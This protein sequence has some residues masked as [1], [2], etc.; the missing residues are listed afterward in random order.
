M[1]DRQTIR[2]E[3]LNLHINDENW[4]VIDCR[5]D[6]SDSSAGQKSYLAGHIPGAAFADLNN[7]L[8]A[9]SGPGTGRHPL[10]SPESAAAFFG[11]IGIDLSTHVVVYDGANGAMAARAW[12]MLRWLGHESVRLLDGGFAAWTAR[13]YPASAGSE[14]FQRKAFVP[15]MRRDCVVHTEELIEAGD[16]IAALNLLDARDGPRFR[17]EVEP[18]DRVAGHIP[19]AK[20][21][22]FS[23]NLLPNGRWKSRDERCALWHKQ[24]GDDKSTASIAMCGSGV[25][26][27]HLILSA[28]DCGYREPRL[29]VGS[30]S[31]WI[32]D[33][34]RPIEPGGT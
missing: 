2:A 17:G 13:D 6:L 22:P 4:R 33:P 28:V 3:E 8:A 24:L 15:R 18:I 10:P 21:M 11:S 9:P 34:G 16:R 31:E 14:T 32:T 12:W 20:N 26:A 5:F 29:Y 30:W 23:E 19:G 27:C 7:D 25:T 1:G